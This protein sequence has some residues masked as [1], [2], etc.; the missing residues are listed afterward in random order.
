[1]GRFNMWLANV[2]RGRYGMDNLN[3]TIMIATFILIVINMF[4]RSQ[5]INFAVVILLIY[6]YCRMFSRNVNARY[7]ENQKFLQ[8]ES[9]IKRKFGRGG[10]GY[11]SAGGFRKGAAYKDKTHKIL[12]CPSCGEKLRVPQGAG[13]ISITCPHCNTKFIKKV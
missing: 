9:A 1:M 3:R 12:R 5:M 7:A 11:S 6:I 2:M 4:V 8:F 10:S 13:K